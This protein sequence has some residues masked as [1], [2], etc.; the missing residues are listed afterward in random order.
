MSREEPKY[1]QAGSQTRTL[2]TKE[3]AHDA[4]RKSSNWNSPGTDAIPNFWLKKLTAAHDTLA[5][6]VNKKRSTAQEIYQ[7]GLLQLALLLYQK[8]MKPTRQRIVDQLHV[9]LHYIKIN[10]NHVRTQL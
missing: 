8:M 7:S 10:G 9:Y 6:A 2:I 4:I 3:E 5:T 1:A